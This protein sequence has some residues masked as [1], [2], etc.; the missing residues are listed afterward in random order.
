MLAERNARYFENFCLKSEFYRAAIEVKQSSCQTEEILYLK[1]SLISPSKLFSCHVRHQALKVDYLLSG[2]VSEVL[3]G[4]PSMNLKIGL[5]SN[6]SRMTFLKIFL[7]PDLSSDED[8]LLSSQS[9]I[10]SMLSAARTPAT[11]SDIQVCKKSREYA[12]NETNDR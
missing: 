3:F 9:W 2:K 1:L 8:Q 4:H 11:G 12:V 6:S 7:D 5:S 10:S